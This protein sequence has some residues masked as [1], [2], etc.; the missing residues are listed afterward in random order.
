LKV[1]EKVSDAVIDEELQKT[2]QV[3]CPDFV[4][5]LK[6]LLGYHV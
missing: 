3:I 4:M 6:K 2:H 1:L 5:S